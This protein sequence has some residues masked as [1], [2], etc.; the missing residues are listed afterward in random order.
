ME[1]VAPLRFSPGDVRYVL[2]GRRL[3]G[4]RLSH[5]PPAAAPRKIVGRLGTDLHLMDPS[6]VIAF[7]AEGELVHI[8]TSK[9]RYLANH[10]L[11]ALEERLEKP[12]FRRVHRRTIINTDPIRKISP[13]S[14]KRW[15]LKMSNGAEIIVSKRLAGVIR[16]ETNW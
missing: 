13:L 11:R 12:R 8:L 3:G 6:E 5:A 15:L 1:A 2:L 10:S 7:Q 9:A 14:R 16:Q 4:L